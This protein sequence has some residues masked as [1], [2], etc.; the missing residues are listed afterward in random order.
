MMLRANHRLVQMK[1]NINLYM[2]ST[3]D[4]FR[5]FSKHK[6]GFLTFKEFEKLVHQLCKYSEEKMARP[7]FSVLKDMFDVIDIGKD[8]LID[9]KEWSTTFQHMGVAEQGTVNMP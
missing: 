7:N 6:K 5:M 8:G 9:Y 2:T 3:A 4:A 1:E